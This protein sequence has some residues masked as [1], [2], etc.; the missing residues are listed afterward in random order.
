MQD[1]D[2][3]DLVQKQLSELSQQVVHVIQEC[4]EETEIFEDAFGTEKNRILIMES[5]LVITR[6]MS[7]SEVAGVGSKMVI[8]KAMRQELRSRIHFFN[9]RIIILYKK[10]PIGVQEYTGNRNP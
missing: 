9:V 7:E 3:T 8:Q 1:G 10:L 4:K 5:H 6:I 2:T